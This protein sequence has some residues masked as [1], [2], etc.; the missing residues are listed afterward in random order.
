V[1][2]DEEDEQEEDDGIGDGVEK[3]TGTT[4]KGCNALSILRS[5]WLFFLL[6]N[7]LT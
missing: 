2:K 3:K 7:I 5:T 6:W 4:E 1:W